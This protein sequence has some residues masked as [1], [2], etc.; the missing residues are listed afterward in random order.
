MDSR[1][2]I[3]ARVR[4]LLKSEIATE[5]IFAKQTVLYWHDPVFQKFLAKLDSEFVT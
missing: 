5:S 2:C 1:K 4:D 3:I